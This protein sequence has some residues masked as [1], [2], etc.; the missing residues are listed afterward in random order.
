MEN[1]TDLQ[2]APTRLPN[3]SRVFAG[4]TLSSLLLLPACKSTPDVQLLPT[5]R[6]PGT[7]N[8]SVVPTSTPEKMF[9]S[10]LI[11]SSELSE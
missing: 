10:K 11:V 7:V 3:L 4:L 6:T 8:N 9:R 5:P 2:R 1:N